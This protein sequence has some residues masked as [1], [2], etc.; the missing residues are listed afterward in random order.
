MPA[1]LRRRALSLTAG[2]MVAA[3]ALVGCS[4]SPGNPGDG[5]A[6]SETRTVT[7]EAGTTEVPVNPQQIVALDEPAALNMLS[8]GITP[9]VVFDSWRTTVPRAVLTEEGVEIVSTTEFYPDLE[10]VA[11][12]EPDLIVATAAEG[13]TES[14]PDYGS[15]APV[16]GALYAAPSEEIIAAYGEYFE[17]ED[18]AA[19]VANALAALTEE[20]AASQPAEPLS[21]SVLM[22]W[23]QDNMP[24]FMDSENSLHDSIRRAGFTRPAPQDAVLEDGSALGG[25]TPFSPEDLAEH[26]ADVVAVAVALQYNLEGI[27]E[28]PL[29]PSLQAV[30]D[31]R[32]VVVDGDLW[33]SGA[34]FYGYWVLR[35]LQAILAGDAPG[36]ESDGRQR[37]ADFRDAVGI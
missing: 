13:F 29:Y 22:S 11:A 16:I 31:D 1:V 5:A 12:L 21:L 4:S 17:R 37:W 8:I 18:E 9:D 25:W 26:D 30:R 23:A 6:A 32:A 35:D 33:S 34:A 27:T 7:S 2:A 24:L 15:V 28:M 19:A 10:E 3:T 20:V 14:A 36:T